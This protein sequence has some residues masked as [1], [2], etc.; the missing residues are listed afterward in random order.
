VTSTGGKLAALACHLTKKVNKAKQKLTYLS[1]N[2]G[3][4]L[5]YDIIKISK[6]H[7]FPI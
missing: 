7:I 2:I 5:K 4:T 1:T 3:L 6:K